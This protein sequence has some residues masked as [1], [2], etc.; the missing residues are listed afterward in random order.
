MTTHGQPDAWKHFIDDL[1]RS[2]RDRTHARHPDR[3]RLVEYVASTAPEADDDPPL[4]SLEA[5]EAGLDGAAG[6]SASRV[7]LHVLTCSIC[8]KRIHLI[9]EAQLEPAAS[10]PPTPWW[11]PIAA[12]IA[13]VLTSPNVRWAAT[14]SVI[15]IVFLSLTLSLL[16]GNSPNVDEAPP[17]PA[18]RHEPEMGGI[19]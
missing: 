2:A 17:L 1:E 15:G 10:A 3:S 19:G 4:G 11:K 14:A 5:F 9:R 16:P 18:D 6:W 8:R 7:S 12:G 13:R